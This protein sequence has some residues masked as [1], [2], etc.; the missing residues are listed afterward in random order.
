MF[1]SGAAASCNS[2]QALLLPVRVVGDDEIAGA[3]KGELGIG[4]DDGLNLAAC[5]LSV[6]EDEG[7]EGKVIVFA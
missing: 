4:D 1:L 6:A 3:D 7:V 2:A 5:S